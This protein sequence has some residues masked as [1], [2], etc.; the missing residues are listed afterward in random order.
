MR[1]STR[2]EGLDVCCGAGGASVGY[3]R[4][5]YTMTGVDL[6]PMPR[7]PFRFIRADALDV[8]ADR[9]FLDRYDL[10]HVS[11]PCQSK[12]RMSNCRP[13]LA[14]TYADLIATVRNLLRAWGGTWVIENVDGAGLAAQDDLLG[15][16]GVMLCGTMFGLPLYRHRFFETSAPVA[17]PHH[18][19]HLIPA[20]KAGHW[21]PGT[22]ISVEGHCSPIALARKAMGGVNWMTRDE[23]AES[24]PPAYAEHIG[25]ALLEHLREAAA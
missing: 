2:P 4:A 9:A 1:V 8:L 5:G 20:S 17:A 6:A 15:T 13:G 22:I 7:Y 11:P 23:L 19:R 10:V 12:S 14:A 3:D 24:I 18:P 21:K 16:H 25:R